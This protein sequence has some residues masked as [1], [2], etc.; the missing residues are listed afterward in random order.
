MCHGIYNMTGSTMPFCF[1]KSEEVYEDWIQKQKLL[2]WWTASPT[3]TTSARWDYWEWR[4]I[5]PNSNRPIF[6]FLTPAKRTVSFS[7]TYIV[8]IIIRQESCQTQ[9][10]FYR[11]LETPDITVPELLFRQTKKCIGLQEMQQVIPLRKTAPH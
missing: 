2:L 10:C 1:L 3:F 4:C 5:N 6:T 11:S 7:P 9:N 8:T